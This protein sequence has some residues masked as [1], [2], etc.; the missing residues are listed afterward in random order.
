MQFPRKQA[1]DDNSTPHVWN[2]IPLAT[3]LY[4]VIIA[5]LV[6]LLF[7]LI[8]I[9]T[10][11]LDRSWQV[12][13]I[14]SIDPILSRFRTPEIDPVPP[15]SG[16]PSLAA[17]E[18][19]DIRE[20]PGDTYRV[21]GVLPANKQAEVAGT[22]VDELWWAIKV[23]NP[24]MELGWAP[25]EAV[26]I[27][28]ADNVP[29]L[30]ADGSSVVTP[31]DDAPRVQALETTK[32]LYGPG[33]DYGVIGFLEAG[34]WAEVIGKDENGL[35]WVI[36]VPYVENGQG[37]VVGEQVIPQNIADIA[38]MKPSEGPLLSGV[39]GADREI[40]T[41]L[42][43][44]NVRNG[45][46]LSYNKIGVLA[47]GQQA[48]VIG[49]SDDGFWL[50]IVSPE[51]PNEQG[52]ISVDYVTPVDPGTI[53]VIDLEA[54]GSALVIPTPEDNL[55][56]ITALTMV[57]IRSGPG[58]Q[59]EILGRLEQGQRAEVVG[60]SAD[61][62]WWVIRLSFQGFENGWVA[63]NFVQAENVQSVPILE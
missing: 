8:V 48:A 52:W 53:P 17:I 19:I 50:L 16:A 34:E 35:W 15:A 32:I 39:Q 44:V 6:I 41:A 21:I 20:G 40:V 24:I 26:V 7:L 10:D 47:N 38:V 63:V 2:K 58:L 22:S 30:N 31:L 59:F 27:N 45:P 14:L 51:N 12:I 4:F 3:K 33:P 57:N 23:F 11:F 5:G 36:K 60:V 25:A 55:P 56:S 42:A 18:A 37:W 62:S 46:G 49:M 29:Q 61:N 13:E 28:N 9:R 54:Q 1:N 43:N